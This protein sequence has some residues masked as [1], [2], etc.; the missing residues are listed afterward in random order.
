[1]GQQIL[2]QKRRYESVS[3]CRPKFSCKK[4]KK[5]TDS[6]TCVFR[7]RVRKTNRLRRETRM[8]SVRNFLMHEGDNETMKQ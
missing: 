4:N 3:S 2:S 8:I 7:D 6:N 1:M 5:L